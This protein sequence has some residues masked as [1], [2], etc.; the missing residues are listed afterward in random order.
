MGKTKK[1]VGGNR[2]MPL[3]PFSIKNRLVSWI[4]CPVDRNDFNCLKVFIALYIYNDP[5]VEASKK[6]VE[7]KRVFDWL[8]SF[9]EKTTKNF[10]SKIHFLFF[11]DSSKNRTSC[12]RNNL[13]NV[14]SG[15]ILPHL[16]IDKY[17]IGCKFDTG[18]GK[19]KTNGY[20]EPTHAVWESDPSTGGIRIA[21]A[22]II[23]N[24]NYIYQI[25]FLYINY[26]FVFYN[27][28]ILNL[29]IDNDENKFQFK[30]LPKKD[31]SQID[32]TSQSTKDTEEIKNVAVLTQDLSKRMGEPPC[33]SAK[34][35]NYERQPSVCS[36][37]C[38]MLGITQ[39]DITDI[40]TNKNIDAFIKTDNFTIINTYFNELTQKMP[41]L[42][43][44]RIVPWT[45]APSPVNPLCPPLLGK[46]SVSDAS[47]ASDGADASAA[48]IARA[49]SPP[50]STASAAI[51]RA[52]LSLEL[53]ELAALVEG[54]TDAT[55]SLP[56]PIARATSPPASTASA[57]ITRAALSLELAELA[58]L[59][60]GHTDATSSLPLPSVSKPPPPTKFYSGSLV[61]WKNAKKT[62]SAKGRYKTQVKKKRRK[63]RKKTNKKKN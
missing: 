13:S 34:T 3:I 37:F 46:L 9:V 44:D 15:D 19:I 40:I 18:S 55:S 58:A 39:L 51:T 59:V 36:D 20:W 27:I 7:I 17:H 1:N 45:L 63:K 54:H 42:P 11:V 29:P 48:P 16:T 22:D 56:L 38:N 32:T 41:P 61:E 43:Q 23:S 8:E 26:W 57:A 2:F 12:N 14:S 6:N 49:T 25:Y 47:D 10:M 31:P 21:E 62:S 5:N 53:A 30:N 24:M 28:N 60:E 33:K 52:A 4:A 50:A 35:K